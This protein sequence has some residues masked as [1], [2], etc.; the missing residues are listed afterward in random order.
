MGA[1]TKPVAFRT[2]DS[3]D[4]IFDEQREE[5]NIDVNNVVKSPPA[6]ISLRA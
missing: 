6:L 3:S 1:L 4:G 2:S 5:L